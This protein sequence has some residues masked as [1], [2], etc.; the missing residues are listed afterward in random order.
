MG[1]KAFATFMAAPHYAYN[2]LKMPG[3]RGNI[4]VRGDAKLAL[5]CEH[6]SGKMADAAIG[7]EED[8]ADALAKYTNGVDSD[9]PTILKKPTASSLASPSFEASANTRNFD[10]TLGDSSKQVIIGDGLSPA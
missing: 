8:K 1:R 2:L 10:L 3:P 6:E 5:E 7:A 4:T 9:D